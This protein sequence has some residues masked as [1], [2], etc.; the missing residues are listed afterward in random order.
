MYIKY[1][2][3]FNKIKYTGMFGFTE[4][5]TLKF[6]KDLILNIVFQ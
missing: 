6:L 5:E 3:I 4:D 2:I 1:F